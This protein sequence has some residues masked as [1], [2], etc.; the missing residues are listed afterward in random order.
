MTAPSPRRA[1]LGLL[2]LAALLGTAGCVNLPAN[3]TVRAIG[4]QA[5]AGSGA[6]VRVWPQAPQSTDGPLEIVEGFL[7]TAASDPSNLSI[8]RAYLTGDAL[9]W[10]PNRVVVFSDVSSPDPVANSGGG[11]PSGDVQVQISGTMIAKVSDDGA[12]QQVLDVAKDA[13]YTFSLSHDPA[14]G[15]RIDKLPSDDFGILLTQEAF[16]ANYAAY[17]LYYLN[18]DSP[19]TSM[20][21]IPD[22]QRSQAGDAAT[23]QSLATALLNGPPDPLTGIAEVAVPEVTLGG[24][25]TIGPDDTA[26]VP[27]KTQSGCSGRALGPCRQLA[28]Q[29]LATFSSLASV[30]GVQLVDQQGDPLVTSSKM[31]ALVDEY[32]IATGASKGTSFYFLDTQNHQVNHY[33]PNGGA[34]T[35]NPAQV[36][37]D[38]R[39]YSQLA[40]GLYAGQTWAAVV[41]DKGSKLYLAPPGASKDS[42]PVWPGHHISSLTWDAFGHLWFLDTVGGIS[43]L[44]RLDLTAGLQPLVQ[45]VRLFGADGTVDQVAV[46]PDG[47]R[48]AVS[49]SGP[50]TTPGSTVYSV[51]IGIVDEDAP[52]G[53]AVNL[54]YG[55]DQ[56]VVYHWTS[57]VDI[58]WRA[59]QCLAVL[60]SQSA[61][62]PVTVAEL[63]S[64]GSPVMNAADLNP[65]TFNPPTG[66]TNVEWNGGAL[67]VATK[68]GTGASTVEQIEQYSFAAGTWG[69]ITSG[70]S[71]EYVN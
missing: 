10:R 17:Y 37:P 1:A 40:V 26:T 28:N 8:A 62:S 54:G 46:A 38:N 41:D 5:E 34:A 7:Q 3:T 70:Y 27:I 14:K 55:V 58:D 51:G 29:L 47:H 71:P 23:A 30:S 18:Q 53:L 11:S 67:L 22:Y 6:D 59:S 66:A 60:G 50:G 64:D 57:V 65:V 45:P 15:Y 44:Y 25:V 69:S 31:D 32:H 12:Y 16:R 61:S 56:P 19:A 36:G 68:S 63:N 33:E 24:S 49:Y 21:P 2:A 4:K 52:S 42:P 43:S 20:I 35:I 9:N 39:K 48:M 13:T